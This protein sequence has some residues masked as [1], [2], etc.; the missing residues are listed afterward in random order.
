MTSHRM[1]D[2]STH[3]HHATIRLLPMQKI[4]RPPAIQ[5]LAS[6]PIPDFAFPP[7][8]ICRGHSGLAPA[9]PHSPYQSPTNPLPIIVQA[10][11]LPI[12]EAHRPLTPHYSTTLMAVS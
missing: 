3:H 5:L 4:N 7:L 12:P 11:A 9:A 1:N 6:C 8:N 2:Y 10:L